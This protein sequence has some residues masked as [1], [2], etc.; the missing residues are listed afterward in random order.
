MINFKVYGN[1][2]ISTVLVHG[3]PGAAGEMNPLA[4]ELESQYGVI[5]PYQTKESI[6]AQVKE[7][8]AIILAN[9]EYPVNLIGHSWG[10][11]LSIIL[12][13]N[14]P[15]IVKKMILVSSGSFEEHYADKINEYRFNRL[16]NK[17]QNKVK[18]LLKLLKGN[19]PL[20]NKNL[21]FSKLGNIFSK[22]DSFDSIDNNVAPINCQYHIFCKIWKEASILRKTG[23][24]LA[25]TKTITCP[26]V[27]I[28]GSYDT[29]SPEGVK[30]P[31]SD[32]V[33]NFKF[34]LLQKCGHT[35]W[36]EKHAQNKFFEIIKNEL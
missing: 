15:D 21:A 3:G 36:F 10:A 32:N 22:A 16:N 31:L 2:P 5:E 18:K 27:A 30:I 34:I 8:K 1:K 7:L 24:L 35:P 11:W 13:S 14:Y 33:S 23:K 25:Y 4:L 17:E 28:H 6:E 20:N 12:A 9:C 19:I 26:V 29:H